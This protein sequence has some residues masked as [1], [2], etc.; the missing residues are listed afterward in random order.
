MSN[1]SLEKSIRTCKVD[2]AWAPRVES[3]RFFNPNLMVCPVWNGMDSAG[4]EVC[5]DSFYTKNAGCNSAEDRVMVENWLRPMYFEYINLA[6]PGVAG[7]IYAANVAAAGGN[8]YFQQSMPYLEIGAS[9]ANLNSVRNCPGYGNFGLQ[10]SS[11]VLANCNVIPGP[12]ACAAGPGACAAAKCGNGSDALA[13]AAYWNNNNQSL[14]AMEAYDNRVNQRL[15]QG[16][17]SNTNKR[18]SGF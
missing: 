5:P 6:E 12:G 15:Q 9:N 13:A 18:C 7:D 1:L 11:E 16:F 17:L 14:T 4:R 2:T 8:P 10:M 3:D